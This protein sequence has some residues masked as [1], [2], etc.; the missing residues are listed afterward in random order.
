MERPTATNTETLEKG[1]ESSQR[2]RTRALKSRRISDE[3]TRSTG[4][5]T[6]RPGNGARVSAWSA[7][8]QRHNLWGFGLAGSPRSGHGGNRHYWGWPS[9]AAE[10]GA[11]RRKGTLE[12]SLSLSLPCTRSVVAARSKGKKRGTSKRGNKKRPWRKRDPVWRTLARPSECLTHR[13]PIRVP[14][15]K[16]I[17]IHR[18]FNDLTDH[19]A[20]S[21]RSPGWSTPNVRRLTD[22]NPIAVF[23]S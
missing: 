3:E 23:T 15:S 14:R 13:E 7:R 6:K 4:T 2:Q 10:V 11:R 5:Q 21:F 16:S 12:D 1:G 19:L 20:T 22:P 17:K 18:R 8:R 9:S